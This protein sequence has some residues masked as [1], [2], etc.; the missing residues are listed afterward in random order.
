MKS[1]SE[2]SLMGKDTSCVK[3][4][5]SVNKTCAVNHVHSYCGSKADV[6]EQM[7]LKIIVFLDV[8]PYSQDS[9]GLRTGRQRIYSRRGHESYLFSTASRLALGPTQ[10]P[11]QWVLWALFW[12]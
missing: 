7:L 5:T 2:E 6:I 9:D 1:L 12:R 10:P 11:I 8:T 4:A 3:P